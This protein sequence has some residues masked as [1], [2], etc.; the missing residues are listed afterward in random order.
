MTDSQKN[1]NELSK[2]KGLALYKIEELK[3]LENPLGQAAYYNDN[4][5]KEQKK[6]HWKDRVK[7]KICGKKFTRSC[8]TAHKK[9]TYHKL[10]LK[11]HSKIS[12]LMTNN[13]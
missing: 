10:H 2:K 13:D 5:K 9:T 6:T 4:D 7:C 11:F 3:E 8:R 12:K 1:R